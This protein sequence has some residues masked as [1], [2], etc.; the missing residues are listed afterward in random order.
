MILRGDGEG[1]VSR[2][3][4]VIGEEKRKEIDGEADGRI[5]EAQKQQH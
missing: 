3:K 2:Q 5:A 4:K 1:G